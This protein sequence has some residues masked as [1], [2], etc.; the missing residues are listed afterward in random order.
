MPLTRE[1]IAKRAAQELKDGYFVNL[2]IGIPTFVGNYLPEG[3]DILLHSE[4]G[5]LG[6]GP[7]PY[8]GEE[9]ADLVNASKATVSLLRGA[10]FF[11][12]AES[13]AMV[14][15][16]HM[17]ATILGSLQVSEKGDL[18]NWTVPGKMMKGV[19]GAMDIVAGTRL[20]IVTMEHTTKDGKPKILKECTLPLTAK[21]V[22]N[23]IVTDLGVMEVTKKGLVLKE[24]APGVTPEE[25]QAKTEPTLIIA[26]DLK[27]VEV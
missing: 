2:G 4:N 24:V 19:G 8:E 7:S 13:F 23:L 5:I 11:S 27:E 26:D 17:D 1:Q 22:V 14:R 18:A 10:S 9:D 3:A 15:G 16:G 6:Y 21:G 12:S 20:V 25:V